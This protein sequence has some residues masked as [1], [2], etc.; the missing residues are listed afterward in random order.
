MLLLV[1]LSRT[2]S[3]NF[4]LKNQSFLYSLFLTFFLQ[5]EGKTRGE[6]KYSNK[7][8]NYIKNIRRM[9]M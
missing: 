5:M 1:H 8:C 6:N 7:Y 9:T 4:R 2:S 3:N